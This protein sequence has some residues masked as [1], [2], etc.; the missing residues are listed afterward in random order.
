MKCS[1]F[2]YVVPTFVECMVMPHVCMLH[3]LYICCISCV[4]VLRLNYFSVS[5]CVALVLCKLQVCSMQISSRNYME[6][7]N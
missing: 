5:S 1:F 3:A 4:H 2:V 6:C 7:R